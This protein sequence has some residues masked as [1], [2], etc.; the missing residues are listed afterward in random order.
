MMVRFV[1]NA[2]LMTAALTCI[3]PAQ[4]GWHWFS[5]V[6]EGTKEFGRQVARDTKR[7]NCWP[8]PFVGP[9]RHA[10]RSP[11]A[12][13]VSNGWRRQNLLG[14]HHFVDKA[15]ELNEAGRM[16]VRWILTEAPQHHRTVYVHKTLNPELTAARIDNVQQYATKLIPQGALP[17]VLETSIPVRGWPAS[18]ADI[19]GR[20][21]EASTPDPR[22]PDASGGGGSE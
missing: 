19:I 20:K 4:A 6:V 9:D 1:R 5:S 3:A 10:V 15:G 22:L 11:F 14:N 18:Q 7:R 21:F 13:M 16:K 17:M 12:I 2:V 8:Q